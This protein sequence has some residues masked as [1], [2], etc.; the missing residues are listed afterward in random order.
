MADTTT[1]VYGLTKPGNLDPSGSG[2]WGP[3]LNT[4]FDTLDS[5]LARPRIQFQSPTV[6][7]TT[8]L[9]LAQG[10]GFVFT[11][12]QATTIAFSNVPTSSFFV[13]IVCLI[14][15]G[16]AFLV[17]WPASVVWTTGQPGLRASG[18]D[19]VELITRDGGT[20]WYASAPGKAPRTLFIDFNKSTTSTSEASITSYTLPASTL[21]TNGQ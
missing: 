1:T 10:R 8:T 20:T 14:T 4:N 17:T 3:K 18:V 5:E 13:R 21:S 15:N 7:S 6:G 16:G 11:V 2:L 19:A 9:D 12:S